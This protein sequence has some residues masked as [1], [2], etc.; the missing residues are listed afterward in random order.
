M[1]DTEAVCLQIN[2]A[3]L[4]LRHLRVTLPHHVRTFA[5]QVDEIRVTLDAHHSR[6]GRFS[7]SSHLE[8]LAEMR[9]YL[10]SAA[11]TYGVVVDEVNY[12]PS[13]IDSVSK[14]FCEGRIPKKA[15]NGSA[16]YPYVFGLSCGSSPFVLHIDSDMFFGGGSRRWVRDAV[17]ALQSDRGRLA[18]SPLPGPPRSDG[19]LIKQ[20]AARNSDAH[21]AYEFRTFSTRVFLLDRRR[22]L[23]RELRIPLVPARGRKWVQSMLND[24][25]PY[26]MLEDGLSELMR[27]DRLIRFDFLGTDG[28]LWS[29]HPVLRSERFYAELPQIVERIESGDIP[30]AQRGDYDLNDSMIDWSDVRHRTTSWYKLRRQARHAV[31]NMVGHLRNGTE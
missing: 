7:T 15:Y 11:A 8:K 12:S 6:A 4:D 16:F 3:P 21:F 10:A 24:T 25:S 31:W 26:L 27:R 2:V 14:A 9:S 30:D 17:T 1:V 18:C 23:S 20:R 28:G 29:L 5:G 13:V 22:F 19:R